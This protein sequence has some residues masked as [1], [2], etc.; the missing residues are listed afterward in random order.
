MVQQDLRCIF[1]EIESFSSVL[2]GG[3]NKGNSKNNNDNND[4]NETMPIRRSTRST[5]G[6]KPERYMDQTWVPGANNRHCKGRAVDNWVSGEL[7]GVLEPEDEPLTPEEIEFIAA[8][9]EVARGP[10][11]ESEAEAAS[12]SGSE[13][14]C[15]L[16]DVT[17]FEHA[18]VTYYLGSEGALYDPE[19]EECVG[20]WDGTRVISLSEA[21]GGAGGGG[22]D[23]RKGDDDEE[24]EGSDTRTGEQRREHR[25]FVERLRVGLQLLRQATWTGWPG[26]EAPSS[27]TWPVASARRMDWKRIHAIIVDLRGQGVRPETMVWP[28]QARVLELA[29][30]ELQRMIRG[31][32]ARRAIEQEARTTCTEIEKLLME[33]TLRVGKETIRRL[34]PRGQGTMRA[35]AM[36]ELLRRRKREEESEE[37]E[38]ACARGRY[39]ARASN[40]DAEFRRRMAQEPRLVRVAWARCCINPWACQIGR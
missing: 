38:I 26:E 22:E 5:K 14:E 7:C 6:K 11:S 33:W 31:A 36:L 3:V 23:E 37:W 30:T 15:E 20:I 1:A 21:R 29:A 24:E 32:R 19:T 9:G 18:G 13:S 34:R 4:N 27:D 35:R 40:S 16:E 28:S 39:L 10:E 2:S 25:D 17:L 12:E 8:E